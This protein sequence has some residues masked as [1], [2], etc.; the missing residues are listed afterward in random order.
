MTLAAR[1]VLPVLLLAAV[2]VVPARFEGRAAPPVART[3]GAAELEPRI[4]LPGALRGAA[5]PPPG[6]SAEPSPT[7][8]PLSREACPGA[9]AYSAAAGG[10][11]LYVTRDGVPV[12]AD[13][14]N[15]GAPDAAWPL[16]SGTK[17]FSGVMAAA[18]IEDGLLAGWDERVA[19]TLAEWR[20][21]PR[22]SRITV[23]QLLSLTS[24]LD[25][26]AVGSVPTYA[27]AVAAPAVAEPGARF[28]YGPVP[29]Q[30]FGELMRR[31]LDGRYPD[32]LAYLRERILEPIGTEPAAWRRGPDG[33]PRLP[34]GASFTAAE[35][36][37]FGDLVRRHGR[38]GDRQLVRE[39]LLAEAF[40]GSTTRPTYGLT[41]WLLLE[42]DRPPAG[43]PAR[44][45]AAKGAGVQRLYVLDRY[46]IVA[47]RQTGGA[48]DAPEDEARFVDAAFLRWL[49]ADLGIEPQ[50]EARATGGEAPARSGN[51]R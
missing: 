2:A 43:A 31:K 5:F 12:C 14:P 3:V 18:A 51:G 13:Y 33:M 48:E 4:W 29:F 46:G 8:A 20:G 1:R 22:K 25:A 23:R 38:W 50:G 37:V 39:D 9:A 21:D 41:W 34:S 26:G 19:D 42:L 28:D 40:K 6:G 47:V 32:P 49:L 10:V 16:A 17:S 30:V 36:A 44:V 15:G 24:G 7:P 35:W 45:V 27:E 11:S